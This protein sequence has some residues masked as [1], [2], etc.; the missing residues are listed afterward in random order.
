MGFKNLDS[1]FGGAHPP[2]LH[3]TVSDTFVNQA[4]V[5]HTSFQIVYYQSKIVWITNK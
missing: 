2:L 5:D 4:I 3:P 1:G